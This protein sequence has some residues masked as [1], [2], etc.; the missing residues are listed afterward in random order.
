MDDD[1][2]GVGTVD[3][4]YGNAGTQRSLEIDLLPGAASVVRGRAGRHMSSG[5]RSQATICRTTS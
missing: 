2:P 3:A 1:Q 5:A 4:R